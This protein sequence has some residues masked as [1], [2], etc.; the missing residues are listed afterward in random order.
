MLTAV[1]NDLNVR[2]ADFE[3]VCLDLPFVKR[4]KWW[5]PTFRS[6]LG[7][8]RWLD[9]DQKCILSTVT[10]HNPA[11]ALSWRWKSR[12]GTACQRPIFSVS[13]MLLARLSYSKSF[14]LHASWF[15][16]IFLRISL[17]LPSARVT[18]WSFGIGSRS[19][20]IFEFYFFIDISYALRFPSCFKI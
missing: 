18:F 5:L 16:K 8:M 4:I 10:N 7:W 15:H 19:C 6:R 3:K 9:S 17:V 13:W 11:A 14:Q 12:A 2:S 20:I 1:R